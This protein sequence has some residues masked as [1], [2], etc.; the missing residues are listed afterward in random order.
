[1]NSFK[2]HILGAD[3]TFYEGECESLIVPTS[4]GQYGIMAGHS[5]VISAIVPGKLTYRAP[6]GEDVLASVS[7]GLV[8]VEGN[9]VVVLVDSAERPEDID[10]IRAKQEADAAKEAILQKRSIHEYRTAQASLARAASR[11]R[12]KN[13]LNN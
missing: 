7:F 5:D 10:I 11:L 8:K 4:D 3:D 12:I 13:S 6:G 1:M 9:D 2:V